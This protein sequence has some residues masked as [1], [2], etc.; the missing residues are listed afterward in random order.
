MPFICV[1]ISHFRTCQVTWPLHLQQNPETLTSWMVSLCSCFSG[2]WYLPLGHSF[3]ADFSGGGCFLFYSFYTARAEDGDRHSLCP[4]LLLSDNSI[5]IL[6]KTLNSMPSFPLLL[7]LL[8]STNMGH[9]QLSFLYD[10]SSWLTITFFNIVLFLVKMKSSII[11]LQFLRS[12]C[13]QWS[14]ILSTSATYKS[15]LK[16]FSSSYLALHFFLL[17][18]HLQQQ[19]CYLSPYN[20]LYVI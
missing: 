8:L 13:L 7:L 1:H 11:G 20:R 16:D 3:P 18:Y 2:N 9:P 10:F 12:S 14:I 4:S 17:S 15:L 5:S 6:S 19:L